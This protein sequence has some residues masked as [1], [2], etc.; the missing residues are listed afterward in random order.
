MA[1]PV[2]YPRHRLISDTLFK[3]SRAWEDDDGDGHI[4]HQRYGWE[5]G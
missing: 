4:Q 1:G 5:P 3:Q 2:D